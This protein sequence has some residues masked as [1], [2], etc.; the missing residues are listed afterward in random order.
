MSKGY[1]AIGVY[2]PKFEVNIGSLWRT[3]HIMGASML[4]TVGA[5]Y[6]QQASD[7]P[8]SDKQIPLVHFDTIKQVI[9]AK[10]NDIPLLGIELSNNSYPLQTFRHPQSAWYLLGAEDRGI[11]AGVLDMCDRTLEISTKEPYSLNVA[12]AG[13]IVIY[14]RVMKGLQ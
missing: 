14:D 13:S 4:F 9:E 12:V 7:T 6:Q 5:R 1:F 2:E 11:P 10:Q 8:K 3:A